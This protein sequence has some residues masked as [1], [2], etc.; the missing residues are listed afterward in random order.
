MSVRFWSS[1]S[2]S[3]VLQVAV[4]FG[5]QRASWCASRIISTFGQE[6]AVV[7][8]HTTGLTSRVRAVAAGH[9]SDTD[10]AFAKSH[11]S[12]RSGSPRSEGCRPALDRLG[13]LPAILRASP[14]VDPGQAFGPADATACRDRGVS[15]PR[16][17]DAAIFLFRMRIALS[18]RWISP[19]H[20]QPGEGPT[21][22]AG[23]PC[24]RF[25]DLRP[26]LS[27]SFR[28][29]R[30]GTMHSLISALQRLRFAA[31]LCVA[32]LR[33]LDQ[34]AT[35]HA[36]LIAGAKPVAHKGGP[37]ERARRQWPRRP[38]DRGPRRNGRELSDPK[39]RPRFPRGCLR[40][41]GKH[42]D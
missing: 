3:L 14:E 28:D 19:P 1:G 15:S 7:Q 18:D 13:A 24:F 26:G 2:K 30:T 40:R 27:D 4:A 8:R 39:R 22:L 38:P 5:V 9:P 31:N 29:R 35:R 20:G 6:A 16:L 36:A 25:H 33:C 23:S 21:A 10:S 12:P 37:W 41:G 42:G 11:P 32:C 34:H 17:S